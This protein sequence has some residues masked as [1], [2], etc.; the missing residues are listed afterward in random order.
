M[1]QQIITQR[2]TNTF[3]GSIIRVFFMNIK[4]NGIYLKIN[5]P[6]LKILSDFMLNN[7]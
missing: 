6:F 3:V 1:K 2:Y 7:Y 5:S 4:T